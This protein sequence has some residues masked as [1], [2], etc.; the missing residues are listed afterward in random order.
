MILESFFSMQYFKAS[1]RLPLE[2]NKTAWCFCVHNA[3][4]AQYSSFIANNFPE[5]S[6]EIHHSQSDENKEE[7]VVYL[8]VSTQGCG[9]LSLKLMPCEFLSGCFTP[10]LLEEGIPPSQ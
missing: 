2:N 1:E 5:Q 9:K 10:L 4:Y 7:E 3:V 8:T 6:S